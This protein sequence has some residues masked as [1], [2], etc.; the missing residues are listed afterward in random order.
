MMKM[1]KILFAKAMIPIYYMSLIMHMDNYND[2]SVTGYLLPVKGLPLIA[3]NRG[4]GKS[5]VKQL[6]F[7]LG[8]LLCQVATVYF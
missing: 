8:K 3:T 1:L 7:S 5:I 6:S 4:K 2:C